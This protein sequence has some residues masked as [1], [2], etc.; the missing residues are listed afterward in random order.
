MQ[1]AGLSL[2]QAPPLSI[3]M[4]FFFTAPVAMIAG[5]ALLL[6]RGNVLFLTGY[7]PTTLLF[8]HL[9]TLG[10][11]A[12]V[13]FGALYQMTPVVAATP[14]PVIRLGHGV[15]LILVVGI[16]LLA[17]AA[18]GVLPIGLPVGFRWIEAAVIGFVLTV[19]IALFRS[20]T[21]NPT[22]TGMRLALLALFLG[23]TLGA[24]MER[25]L[26]GTPIVSPR[27]L[28]IQV[29]LCVT[30]LGWIGGLLVSVSWQI[31][32][33]FYLTEPASLRSS[34]ISLALLAFGVLAP[35]GVL[36]LHTAGVG[37]GGS[38]TARVAAFL[39]LPAVAT[40]WV[41]QPI[42]TL[43][44]LR[45]RRRRRV[46][47]SLSFWKASM[48]V[49]LALMPAAVLAATT[50]DHR[51][52]IL[53]GWLAVFGWAGL[54]VH[55]MLTRIVPFLVWFH[56][57]SPLV[58]RVPVP[59]VRGLLPDAW[60]RT[61]F[62]V[63]VATLAVGAAAIALPIPWMARVAGA[64]LLLTAGT[65]LRMLVHVVRQRPPR[66]SAVSPPSAGR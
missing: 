57:F 19:G 40:V 16:G 12:M 50:P 17:G 52:K 48:F 26:T 61:A 43:R 41:I 25:G 31:V 60:T 23:A 55:G 38:A 62:R 51:W 27:G 42:L 34:R 53:F 1:T 64:L 36:A 21:R 15:H 18:L 29:H 8:T 11:L 22:V 14:V 59:S 63:H 58:G 3:P 7:L 37:S 28:W 45:N 32:P 30:L 46:D 44:S 33:M 39:A 56:R 20:K 13:M 24:L 65:L 35:V 54:A 49:A 66:A 10:F 6:A 2:D 5:G 47:A 4:T 9:G